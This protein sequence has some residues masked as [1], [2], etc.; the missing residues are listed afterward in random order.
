MYEQC[1]ILEDRFDKVERDNRLKTIVAKWSAGN[2]RAFHALQAKAQGFFKARVGMEIDLSGTLEVHEAAFLERDLIS[3]F[4]R[5]ERGELP[6]FS[7]DAFRK[8][9]TT[10]SAAY[11]RT[12]TGTVHNW[13]TVTPEGI[14]KAQQAWLLYRD[15]WVAFGK[16]R[17]PDVTEKSW[18]TWLDQQRTAMLD[19]FLH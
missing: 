9:D 5:F 10:M 17:Y 19:R 8:A 11:S 12:Q 2:R 3:T 18:K 15:A 16:R 6:R 1:A 4:E 14:R 7:A 13:G